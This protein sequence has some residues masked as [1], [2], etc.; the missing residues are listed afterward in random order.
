MTTN[1]ISPCKFSRG[2]L[3]LVKPRL[4]P[5]DYKEP[6][7]LVCD[8]HVGKVAKIYAVDY[9]EPDQSHFRYVILVDDKE[10]WC[11]EHRLELIF[12]V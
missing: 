2:D 3:V 1:L 5:R 7:W 9:S 8:S 11:A 4:V 10:Y 6:T 12:S